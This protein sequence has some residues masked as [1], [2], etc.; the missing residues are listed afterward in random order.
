MRR[1]R[2]AAFPGSM[3]GI[4]KENSIM[5][6]FGRLIRLRPGKLEE[7]EAYHA[8]VWPEV[9]DTIRNCNIH[10][11]SIFHH[12]GYLFSYFEYLGIDFPADMAKMAADPKTQEWWKI[13]DP[14]QEPLPTR[15]PGEWWV[16][17]KE[18]FHTD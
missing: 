7:Y 8:A 6:R 13:M 11:Y 5:K 12:D 9:L 10:N 17:M 4:R 1:V 18:V 2:N 16:D 14:L 3:P 15:Q